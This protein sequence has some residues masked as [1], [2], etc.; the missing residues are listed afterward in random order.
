M[1]Q[2]IK[3]KTTGEILQSI[4]NYNDDVGEKTN[5]TISPYRLPEYLDLSDP[6]NWPKELDINQIEIRRNIRGKIG[7]ADVAFL[8]PSIRKAGRLYH[9]IGVSINTKLRIVQIVFG[10]IRLEALKQEGWKTLLYPSDFT[11]LPP[12]L[13]DEQFTQINISENLHRKDNNKIELGRSI[14][15]LKDDKGMSIDDIARMIGISAYI[16]SERYSLFNDIPPKHRDKIGYD[17]K[18]A[19]VAGLIDAKTAAQVS[20]QTPPRYRER[21]LDDVLVGKLTHSQVVKMNSIFRSIS[22]INPITNASEDIYDKIFTS[23]GLTDVA[24]LKPLYNVEEG[25]KLM[26][27]TGATSVQAALLTILIDTVREKYP[28]LLKLD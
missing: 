11:Y 20:R 3:E 26:K 2:N 14:A 18:N 13:T 12:D 15:Y 22:K 24:H 10:H 4:N 9:A 25:K 16:V 19:H 7:D 23:I 17:I 8:R 6:N 5:H 1:S 21:I 28:T 27:E